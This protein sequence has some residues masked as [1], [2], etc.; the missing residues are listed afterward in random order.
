[1][2]QPGGGG[3]QG[4]Q[5]DQAAEG[6]PGPGQ[7]GQRGGEGQGQHG[8]PD[9]VGEPARAGVL[10]PA[11]TDPGLDEAEVGDT[12]QA[13]A[14]AE[15]QAGEQLEGEQGGKAPHAAAHGTDGP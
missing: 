6:P 10:D 9:Q 15:D 4:Q 1:G 3:G 8:G 12:G 7:P 2:A 14:P 11:L 5:R 13:P